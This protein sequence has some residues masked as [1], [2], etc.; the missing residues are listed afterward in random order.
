MTLILKLFI[1][2]FLYNVFIYK[3]PCKIA[4]L[5]SNFVYQDLIQI[6]CNCTCQALKPLSLHVFFFFSFSFLFSFFLHDNFL[7]THSMQNFP[8]FIKLVFIFIW[9]EKSSLNI[10]FWFILF[11]NLLFTLFCMNF[12]HPQIPWKMPSFHQFLFIK[13][14]LFTIHMGVHMYKLYLI[15]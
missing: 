13:Y 5:S 3:I 2:L 4:L 10:L 6:K 12:F 8:P 14:I 9:F 7:S 11:L 1:T 15:G